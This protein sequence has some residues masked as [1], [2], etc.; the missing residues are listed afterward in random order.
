MKIT[1]N[2]FKYWKYVWML[3]TSE[4]SWLTQSRK[5]PPILSFN[6]LN[7]FH[8]SSNYYHFSFYGMW[9]KKI[10]RVVYFRLRSFQKHFIKSLWRGDTQ[11][12]PL[13]ETPAVT[14][15]TFNIMLSYKRPPRQEWREHT[16]VSSLNVH[17]HFK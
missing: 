16:T 4:T 15:N 8:G 1:M 3:S 6:C 5:F 10:S 7:C 9:T 2:F 13:Y 14:L 12:K 17:L 11:S